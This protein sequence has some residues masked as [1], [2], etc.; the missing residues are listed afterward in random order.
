MK[1]IKYSGKQ[2]EMLQLVINPTI[3]LRFKKSHPTMSHHNLN[4]VDK[5][6]LD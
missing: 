5:L 6:L 4:E 2:N 3:G 1:E